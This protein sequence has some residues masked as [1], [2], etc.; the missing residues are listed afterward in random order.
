MLRRVLSSFAAVALVCPVATVFAEPVGAEAREAAPLSPQSSADA[1]APTP[2]VDPVDLPVRK[3]SYLYPGAQ[4]LFMTT[5]LHLIAHVGGVPWAQTSPDTIKENLDPSTWHFDS[6]PYSINNAG[7][8]MGGA[9][10][11]SAARST[12]HDWWT[13]GLYAFGGSA[14]WELF[15]ENEPPSLNDQISTPVGGMFIG[16]IMHRTSRALLYPGYGKPGWFRKSAAWVLDPVGS[17]NRKT[18]G[19]PWARTS[20]P[21]LYAH[22]GIGVQGASRVMGSNG[23]G[24]Q[25]HANLFYE[26]GLTGDKA[27][28]PSRAMDHFEL[29]ASVDSSPEDLDYAFYVRGM[30]LGKGD[31]GSRARGMAGLFGAFDF[32]N[33]EYVRA[34]ILG[35]GPGATGE[36]QIGRYGFLEGT[37]AAYA[38]PWGAAGGSSERE[39]QGRD[40][41][42]GPGLA[43]VLEMKAGRRGFA[44]LRSTTRAYEIAARFAGDDTNEVVVRSTLAAELHLARNHMIGIEGTAGWRRATSTDGFMDTT[45]TDTSREARVFYAITMDEIVGR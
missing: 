3:K 20:P 30:L 34:S 5:G 8:P 25:L 31:W 13:S 42:R 18:W 19:D 24:A 43:Q 22:F 28:Q 27:F 40:H 41:H 1:D 36:V 4:I 39:K 6:D 10:L 29:R 7:H 32:D 45:N 44:S 11:F 21:S 12:G 37:I 15:M 35:V 38:V 14:V 2:V 33:Q 17:F 26:H 16:E 9:V 23:S